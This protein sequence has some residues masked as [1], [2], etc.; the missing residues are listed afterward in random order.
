MYWVQSHHNDPM[1]KECK[2]SLFPVVF[3]VPVRNLS[4]V[5]FALLSVLLRGAFG[6]LFV[7]S[8]C[9]NF[10]KSACSSW[11]LAD[12]SSTKML[13][14]TYSYQQ[15]SQCGWDCRYESA[16]PIYTFLWYHSQYVYDLAALFITFLC[17]FFMFEES[18]EE[19]MLRWVPLSGLEHWYSL[20][21]TFSWLPWIRKFFVLKVSCVKIC[22]KVD[23]P[24]NTIAWKLQH[25]VCML[26]ILRCQLLR[27]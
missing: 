23:I 24:Q 15:G 7:L 17:F 21:K 26:L 25:S 22:R 1:F 5:V 16:G 3:A 14:Y 20:W 10:L 11:P 8:L 27:G 12:Q 19:C 13:E 9:G 4:L 2:K 18:I 6:H